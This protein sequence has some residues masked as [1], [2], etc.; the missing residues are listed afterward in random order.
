LPPPEADFAALPEAR[1]QAQTR[2]RIEMALERLIRLREG[3]FQFSLTD[4]PPRAIKGRDI[5]RETLDPGINPQE[6]LLDLARGMDEDR[7]DSSAA[8]EASF[9][10]PGSETEI[11][12]LPSLEADAGVAAVT[13]SPP[14]PPPSFEAPTTAPAPTGPPGVD[15]GRFVAPRDVS[16]EYTVPLQAVSLELLRAVSPPAAPPVE[17][18]SEPAPELQHQ[19]PAAAPTQPSAAVAPVEP[20]AMPPL[21]TILLVDDEEDVR[22]S[23]AQSLTAGGFQ[24]VEAEDPDSAVK[25]AQRLDK[26]GIAFVLVTDLGLPPA[27]RRSREGSRSSSASGR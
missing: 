3:Q 16:P 4:A 23:L 10:E 5:S 1:R 15:T 25:K 24:V 17:A 6:L 2:R 11:S 14:A 13:E 20:S 19:A 9:A 7:R 22:R 18:P 21:A 8:L 12:P 27:A 26:A